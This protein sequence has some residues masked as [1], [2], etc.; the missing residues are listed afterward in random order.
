MQHLKMRRKKLC[1]LA[2]VAIAALGGVPPGSAQGAVVTGEIRVLL[3]VVDANQPI[4]RALRHYEDNQVTNVAWTDAST[5]HHFAFERDSSFASLFEE[6]SFGQLKV[7]GDTL[8]MAFPNDAEDRTWRQWVSAA[9]TEA[10]SLG[11]NLSDY[12]RYLYILPYRPSD[13]TTSGLSVGDVGWCAPFNYV[14]LGCIFH[15]FGHTIGFGHAAEL[16]PDGT[17]NGTGDKSDGL[18]GAGFNCQANVV[19]KHQ[20][21][22]LT[23]NRLQTFDTA[24]SATFTLAAQSVA[25]ETLQAIEIVNKGARPAI[26]VVDTFVSFRDSA[27]FDA[28]LVSGLPDIHGDEVFDAVLVHQKDRLY[29]GE[30]IYLQALAEGESYAENGV[31]VTVIGISGD[32][33]TVAVTRDPYDPNPHQAVITPAN[34][35]SEPQ[36][37]Q[38][39]DVSITNTNDR[40]GNQLRLLLRRDLHLHRSR[41][42]HGLGQRLPQDRGPRGDPEFSTARHVSCQCRT[43]DL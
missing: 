16:L 17:T 24:G 41:L 37:F 26:G 9:D 2:A 33:A 8:L 10:Q 19:N 12:D 30:T 28:Q 43:R 22:W 14:E 4:P 15:E 6:M 32:E 25:A 18:M 36:Q 7:T 40:V 21:G 1:V 42:G 23:G 5:I 38:T 29:G 31:A 20:V 27:G 13:A 39:Y 11:F 3:M 34:I 35:D